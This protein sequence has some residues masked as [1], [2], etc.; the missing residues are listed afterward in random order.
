MLL[1]KGRV[2]L[3]LAVIEGL[4]PAC[5]GCERCQRVGGGDVGAD[6]PGRLSEYTRTNT[7]FVL[8]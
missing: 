1:C 4:Q 5:V 2:E 3:T 8:E 6:G 7:T